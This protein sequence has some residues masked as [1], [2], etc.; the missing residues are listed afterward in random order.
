MHL[1]IATE[2]K[3]Q[4]CLAGCALGWQRVA[5]LQNMLNDEAEFPGFGFG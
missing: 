3:K 1:K 5:A 2:R 4:T